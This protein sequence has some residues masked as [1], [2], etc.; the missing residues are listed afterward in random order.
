M[1]T[2]DSCGTHSS[3]LSSDTITGIMNRLKCKTIRDSTATAYFNIWR[4]FNNFLIKLDKHPDMWEERITLFATYQIRQGIQSKTLKSYYSS[5]KN[6]LRNDDYYVNDNKVLLNTLAKACC[7]I[8]DKVR[9]N[10]PIRCRLLDLLLFEVQRKY[11]NEPYLEI[12]YKA[13]F[14]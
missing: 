5:I 8:N 14:I 1:N 10:L 7:L 4:V 9:T 13:I 2:T 3:R 12:L 6:V 11:G